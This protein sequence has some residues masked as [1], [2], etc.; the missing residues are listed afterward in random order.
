MGTLSSF[1]LSAFCTLSP[2]LSSSDLSLVRFH[3]HHD[4]SLITLQLFLQCIRKLCECF[5]YVEFTYFSQQ[6]PFKGQ[7]AES[8]GR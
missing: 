2:Y 3:D 8:Q 1:K 6:P 5:T 7:Q 4:A